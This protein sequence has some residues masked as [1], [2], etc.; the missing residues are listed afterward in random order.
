MMHVGTN[1]KGEKMMIQYMAL[2][3]CPIKLSLKIS[4]IFCYYL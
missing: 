2:S 4:A 1:Y 3:A